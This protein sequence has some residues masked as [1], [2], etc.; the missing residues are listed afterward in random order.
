MGWGPH[1]VQEYGRRVI[2]DAAQHCN[3]GLDKAAVV[4]GLCQ[5][6]VAKVPWAVLLVRAVGG[7]ASVAVHGAETGV[8][9]PPL[10]GVVLFPD[11]VCGKVNNRVLPLRGRRKQS[12]VS[13]RRRNE[14]LDSSTEGIKLQKGRQA[15]YPHVTRSNRLLEM[16]GGASQKQR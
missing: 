11:L 12:P 2:G 1:R 13:R 3:H 10:H 9:Q 6:Q 14:G 16:N 5:L 15:G 8:A 4:H 7:A